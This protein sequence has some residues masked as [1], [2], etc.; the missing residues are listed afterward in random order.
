V[1]EKMLV[2]RGTQEALSQFLAPS[3]RGENITAQWTSKKL[4][5]EIKSGNVG[6]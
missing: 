2:W 3:K 1:D 6:A 5:Q 4:Q